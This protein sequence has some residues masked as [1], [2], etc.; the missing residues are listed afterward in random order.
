[1]SRQ[2]SQWLIPFVLVLGAAGALW[3]Y[4]ARMLPPEPPPAEV[5]PPVVAESTETTAPEHPLPSDSAM[6]EIDQAPPVPLPRLDQSDAYFKLEITDLFGVSLGDALVNTGMIERVVA[7]ID[8]LSREHVAEKIR[9]VGAISGQFLVDGQDDS[10][11]YSIST[12]NDQRYD[13]MVNLIV[14]ADSA[15]IAAL[16]RRYYPLFQS[17]YVDLGYPDAYFNDRLVEIIDHLLETPEVSGPIE[18]VRPHVLYEYRDADLEALSSGQKLMLRIG[19]E[20]AGSVK[21]KLRE[22]RVLL[23]TM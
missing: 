17:A 10:G 14:S 16:Y 15:E 22:L 7:T 8:N 2:S 12:D 5:Q 4:W 11:E 19:E 13:V 1:M 9:P 18:L 6:E 23:T 20:H 3:Y 21:I